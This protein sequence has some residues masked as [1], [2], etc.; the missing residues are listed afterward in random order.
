MTTTAQFPAE[1]SD[2]G[3]FERQADAFRGALSTDGSTPYPAVAGRYH[4]Y[5]SLACPWAHRTVIARQ[6]L[7]LT[8]AIG[9]TVVDPCATTA[10][11]PSAPA[12]ATRSI[13]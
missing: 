8:E 13:R 2:D 1:Q 7:G 9:L 6:L 3:D 12:T 5:V 10:A 4:L 11:G